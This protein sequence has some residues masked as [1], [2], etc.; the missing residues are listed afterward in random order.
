MRS[1]IVGV[2]KESF[3]DLVTLISRRTETH[4][5]DSSGK[6][7]SSQVTNEGLVPDLSAAGVPSF[8]TVREENQTVSYSTDSKNPRRSI[9]SQIVTNIRGII[10]IDSDNEY[11]D[12]ETG[13]QAPFKQDFLEAHKAGNL[14]DGMTTDYGPLKTVT[15][16]LLDLGGGQYQMSVS[17]I[18]HLRKAETAS[19][20]EPKTGD[21]SLDSSRGKQSQILV[22]KDGLTLTSRPGNAIETVSTG[23]LPL[24]F[25]IP[26]VRRKLARR[27]SQKQS[28]SVS[29]IGYSNSVERG[30][31]FRVYDRSN[32]SYG[33]FIAEGYRVNFE[34]LGDGVRATTE[35]EVSE[36]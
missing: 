23:E 17:T 15:E 25:G 20:S 21:A 32:V 24:Y 10:A 14:R 11:Y 13:E 36:I 34:A 33:K 29:V 12:P 1:E 28:G 22:L 19:F 26:L 3:V 31:F 9:Q 8:Q 7:I 35:V 16:T 4:N 2:K 5:F 18:D 30:V 6:R 27:T